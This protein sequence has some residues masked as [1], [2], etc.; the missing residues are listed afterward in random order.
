MVGTLCAERNLSRE[1]IFFFQIPP[2]K[3]CD[4]CA[5]FLKNEWIS[6]VLV[7]RKEKIQFFSRPKRSGTK[8]FVKM[9]S[10]GDGLVQIAVALKSFNCS[11]LG[12]IF[13]NL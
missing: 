9:K 1:P 6:L 12:N 4:M 8:Y 10:A 11:V 5:Y 3:C 13:F 2:R 7:L